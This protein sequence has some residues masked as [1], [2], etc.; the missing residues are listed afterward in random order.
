MGGRR[1][2]ALAAH[3]EWVLARVA[4][5]PDLTLRAIVL[6]LADQGVKVGDTAVWNFLRR[7]GISFKKNTARGRAGPARRGP[8]AGAVEAASAP[9]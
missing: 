6:E 7:E 8:Q 5:K 2:F 3:R 4:E 1:P 9:D